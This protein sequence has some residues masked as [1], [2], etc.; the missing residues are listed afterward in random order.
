MSEL[1]QTNVEM[2]EMSEL[3]ICMEE[4]QAYKDAVIAL[5]ESLNNIEEAADM[6]VANAT[7]GSSIVL[8]GISCA[9]R[10]ALEELDEI[11]DM[12]SLY[13]EDEC[14]CEDCERAEEERLEEENKAE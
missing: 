3:D 12:D 7:G 13:E 5:V 4:L 1:D 14:L 6:T 8:N 9:A 10:L 2:E 11:I